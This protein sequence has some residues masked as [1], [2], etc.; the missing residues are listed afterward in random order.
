MCIYLCNL[1]L[2]LSLS[3]SLCMYVYIYIVCVYIYVYRERGAL[4]GG[5]PDQDHP[6]WPQREE[7]EGWVPNS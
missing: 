5:R 1:S 4:R 3:L 6:E 7:E 2:S